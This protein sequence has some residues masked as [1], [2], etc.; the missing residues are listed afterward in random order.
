[1]LD[2]ANLSVN[3]EA[4]NAVNGVSFRVDAGEAVALLGPN[5]AG[6]SSTLRAISRLTP[7]HGEVSFDGRDLRK[8]RPEH[9][10][11]LGLIHVPEGR[12]LFANMSAQENLD[13]GRTAAC[14]RRAA[15]T[16]DEILDIFPLLAK[17][18]S[19]AAWQLSGGEQQVVAIGRALL[20]APRLLL[21]DEPTLGLAPV[22]VKA[23]RDAL[24]TVSTE[25][26]MLMVEQNTRQALDICG[27]GYVMVGGALVFEGDSATLQRDGAL[28][29][30]FLS[31]TSVHE[32]HD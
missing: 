31:R 11:R 27:R 14:G 18:R 7:S 30:S 20:S 15:F 12:R 26:P 1:M 22:V 8:M 3:Y 25:I 19:R 23:V 6:K 28:L 10:A 9:V 17:L 24:V 21:L 13:V 2:V 32:V 5:G 29:D 16:F 4:V